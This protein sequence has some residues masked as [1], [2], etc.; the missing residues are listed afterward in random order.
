MEHKIIWT[1]SAIGDLKTICEYIAKDDPRAAEA[2]GRGI[3]DHVRILQSFPFIGPPY[4]RGT[5][6]P[7]RQIVFRSYRVFYEASEKS[8]EVRVLHVWH[9]ARMNPEL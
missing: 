3:L 1:E 5:F 7:L 6:G 2:V 9:G 8:R 4:P